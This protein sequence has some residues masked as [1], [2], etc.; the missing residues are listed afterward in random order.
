VAGLLLRRAAAGGL[1]HLVE[2]EA[3]DDLA[4]AADEVPKVS[5]EAFAVG[6]A[7]RELRGAVRR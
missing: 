3:A 4:E 7:G 5:P 2:V 1:L 6:I